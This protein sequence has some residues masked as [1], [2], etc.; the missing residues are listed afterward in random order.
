MR[1]I[2]KTELRKAFTNKSFYAALFINILIAVFSAIVT[3]ILFKEEVGKIFSDENPWLP[4]FTLYRYWIGDEMAH[5]IPYIFYT[6]LPLTA[7]LTFGW[8]YASEI[9]NGHIKNVLIRTS[10]PKYFTSK[11]I[12]VF[13]SGAFS[14]LIPIIVNIL[15]VACFIP[16]IKPDVFYRFS[17][18]HYSTLMLSDLFFSKPVLYLLGMTILA[19]V[20]AGIYSCLSLAMSMLAKNK[21]AVTI[22]PFIALLVFN[23]ITG[24]FLESFRKIGELSPLKILHVTTGN[25][26]YLHVAVIEA[27]VFIVITFL[28][29]YLKGVKSDVF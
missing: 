9:K 4:V 20:F 11:Y 2:L 25:S 22:T 26:I 17:Y 5:V 16:A 15:I 19:T 14:A 23:Y 28:I 21:I 18:L 1:L 7:S 10:K 13:S 27:V 6:L 24:L 29:T 12:A 8:S 3:I